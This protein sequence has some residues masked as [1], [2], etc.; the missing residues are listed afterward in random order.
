[1]VAPCRLLSG[2]LVLLQ[3]DSPSSEPQKPSI[4]CDHNFNSAAYSINESTFSLLAPPIRRRPR[5]PGSCSD[6]KLNIR[7]TRVGLNPGLVVTTDPSLPERPRALGVLRS[8][9]SPHKEDVFV[10]LPSSRP[11]F[12]NTSTCFIP[13]GNPACYLPP[14]PLPQPDTAAPYC[15]WSPPFP[16]G[17][18]TPE[19]E[20]PPTSDP[21]PEDFDNVPPGDHHAPECLNRSCS[22]TT[23]RPNDPWN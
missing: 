23:R 5:K 16:F 2:I 9:G 4:I 3:S 12:S 22:P 21:P 17:S 1:M 18:F 14:S 13:V 8:T 10:S 20:G 7:R 15:D 19:V 6:T 11:R